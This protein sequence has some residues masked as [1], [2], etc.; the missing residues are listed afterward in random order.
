M[1]LFLRVE[2]ILHTLSE[3]DSI[4]LHNHTAII[5]MY[6]MCSTIAYIYGTLLWARHGSKLYQVLI[7]FFLITVL[8]DAHGY[9]HFSFINKKSKMQRC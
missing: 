3:Q 6:F 9:Y 5:K 2:F 1:Q 8:W 7:H 4:R